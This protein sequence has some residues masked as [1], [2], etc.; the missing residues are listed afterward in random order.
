MHCNLA[1]KSERKTQKS[2]RSLKFK[3]IL[4]A[5]YQ[6]SSQSSISSSESMLVYFSTPGFFRCLYAID[7]VSWIESGPFFCAA[8]INAA[9]FK[10]HLTTENMCS[11]DVSLP[12]TLLSVFGVLKRVFHDTAGTSVSSKW[13]M[14]M[15]LSLIRSSARLSLKKPSAH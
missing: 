14:L 2:V 11:V 12:V 5:N 6:M 7:T 13:S 4:S 3:Q 10:P 1:N 9:V 15:I 8:Q